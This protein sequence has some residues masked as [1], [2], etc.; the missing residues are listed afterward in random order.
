MFLKCHTNP[1]SVGDF[2]ASA[3]S[4]PP[5]LLREGRNWCKHKADAAFSLNPLRLTV[6]LLAKAIEVWEANLA[7]T[8]NYT[9]AQKMLDIWHKINTNLLEWKTS[10]NYH[11]GQDNEC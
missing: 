11:Y 3:S 1:H 4:L 2:P 9:A 8:T 7:A 6:F 10:T 5:W